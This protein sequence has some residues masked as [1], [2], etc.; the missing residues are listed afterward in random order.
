MTGAPRR[1]AITGVGGRLG[2]ALRLAVGGDRSLVAIPWDRAAFDLDA[3]ASAGALLDRDRP[4]LVIHAAAWTDVDGCA[5]DPDLALARNGTATGILASACAARDIAFASI[6]TNEVFDGDRADGCGYAED[7]PVRPRNPYGAS[8]LAG[9]TATREA[10][11][12]T[13]A[14]A[15]PWIIRIAWLYGPPGNDFPRKIVAAADRLPPGEPLRVV[16]DEWGTPTATD[17][18]AAAILDLITV[19]RGGRL[20]LSAPQPASR[21][22]WA[23]AVLAQVRPDRS[24]TPISRSAFQRASDPPPWGVLDASRAAAAGVILPDWRASLR[25]HLDADPSLVAPL[26]T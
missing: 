8:K 26:G 12:A 16:D 17:D 20:H 3:P 15:G 9:E 2:R 21:F 23:R 24:L 13:A 18:L 11:A 7:D 5:R 10:F 14:V 22:D 1:I 6:S 19:T 25:R 4:D